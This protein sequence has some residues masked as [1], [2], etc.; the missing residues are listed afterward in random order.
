MG[1]PSTRMEIT[2]EEIGHPPPAP[3]PL[4]SFSHGNSVELPSFA[5]HSVVL[6]AMFADPL[7]FLTRAVE[8]ALQLKMCSD[9]WLGEKKLWM[10]AV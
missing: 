9:F 6:D 3:P 2:F 5:F 10:S 1:N 4:L 7:D 8:A